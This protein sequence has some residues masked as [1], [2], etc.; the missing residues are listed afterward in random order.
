[1]LFTVCI[2]PPPPV[3]APVEQLSTCRSFHSAEALQRWLQQQGIEATCA[4][5]NCGDWRWP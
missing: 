3:S 4:A 2:P 5:M 1:M